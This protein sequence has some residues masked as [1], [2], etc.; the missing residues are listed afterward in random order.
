MDLLRLYFCDRRNIPWRRYSYRKNLVHCSNLV[1]RKPNTLRNS[2]VASLG[3]L[4][5]HYQCFILFKGTGFSQQFASQIPVCYRL[6]DSS[7]IHQTAD[8]EMCKLGNLNRKVYYIT[9]ILTKRFCHHF[10]FPQLLTDTTA[11]AKYTDIVK[12]YNLITREKIIKN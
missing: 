7:S 3:N 1:L 2:A 4:F 9:I 10:G 12:E 6:V 5:S 11:E 8:F